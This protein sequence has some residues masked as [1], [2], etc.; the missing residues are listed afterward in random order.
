MKNNKKVCIIVAVII[1][2]LFL[3]S[4]TSVSPITK[5]ENGNSVLSSDRGNTIFYN[6]LPAALK[7]N[8]KSVSLV[9][10]QTYQKY[11]TSSYTYDLYVF[12][13]FDISALS[14]AEQH[15][16]CKD[17]ITIRSFLTN[18]KN[19]LDFKSL[20]MYEFTYDSK[21]ATVKF[22]TPLLSENRY[23]FAQSELT[24]TAEAEQE[25]T[26]PYTN[27]EGEESMLNKVESFHFT[28]NIEDEPADLDTYTG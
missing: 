9:D 26:Y 28:L 12:C 27:S 19:A 13:N 10:V 5:N 2:C 21:T 14:D 22:T 4:C 24:I 20:D 23:S 8:D 25:E 6:T 3:S 7:Y 15:W 11:N 16:L 1:L 18:D 17:D